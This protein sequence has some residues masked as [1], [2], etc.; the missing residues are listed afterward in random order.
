MAPWL[1]E[2]NVFP[3]LGPL[4]LLGAAM[5]EKPVTDDKEVRNDEAEFS[6]I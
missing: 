5:I 2:K 6:A 3:M 4:L 1:L